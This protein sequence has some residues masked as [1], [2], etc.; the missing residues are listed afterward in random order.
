MLLLSDT[1]PL[2]LP[3]GGITTGF[4]GCLAKSAPLDAIESAGPAYRHRPSD[5][6]RHWTAA[7]VPGPARGEAGIG[8]R[9]WR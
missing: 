1:V 6:F 5:A 4:C 8:A 7:A 2:E 9:R 3:S